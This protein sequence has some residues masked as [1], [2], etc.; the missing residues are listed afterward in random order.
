MPWDHRRAAVVTYPAWVWHHRLLA[1]VLRIGG[2]G[3]IAW[4]LWPG[5]QPRR[6]GHHGLGAVVLG[7]AAFGSIAQPLRHSASVDPGS[8]A[9]LDIQTRLT[10]HFRDR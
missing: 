8:L 6:L 1:V 9:P 2:S 3:I 10:A 4:P 7:L 5:T